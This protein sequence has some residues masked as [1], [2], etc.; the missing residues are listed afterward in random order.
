[1]FDGKTNRAIKFI[2][3]TNLVDRP[4]FGV[5]RK[6]NFSITFSK[7]IKVTPNMDLSS[8]EALMGPATGPIINSSDEISARAT[9]IYA[10]PNILLEFT[11]VTK[12]LCR[13]IFL[14]ENEPQQE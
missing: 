10:Y 1:M 8:I 11:Q 13:A 3:N 7:D 9:K 5:W 4:D 2:L 14:P 12:R 6:C